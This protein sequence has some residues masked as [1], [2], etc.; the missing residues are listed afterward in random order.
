MQNNLGSWQQLMNDVSLTYEI[1]ESS[2]VMS[3]PSYP[4]LVLV[5]KIVVN[6]VN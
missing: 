1:N 2:D 3:F 4:Q 6:N 5:E